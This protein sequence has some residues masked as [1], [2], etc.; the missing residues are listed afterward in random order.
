[1]CCSPG[2]SPLLPPSAA[3]CP[4][5]SRPPAT[6]N[7]PTAYFLPGRGEL[8][9]AQPVPGAASAQHESRPQP[10]AGP[11]SRHLFRILGLL[12]HGLTCLT[13]LLMLFLQEIVVTRDA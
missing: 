4:A 10:S 11:L 13:A 7:H 9:L 5:S 3:K 8:S 1:M 2:A 6:P 12:D